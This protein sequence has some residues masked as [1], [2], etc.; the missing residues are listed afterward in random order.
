LENRLSGSI[1][2]YIKNADDLIGA[3]TFPP[4]T[5]IY[6]GSSAQNTSLVNYADLRTT[7]MDLQLN[8]VNFKGPLEWN[9]AFLFNYVKNTVTGYSESENNGIFNYL[10]DPYTP[11][12]GESRDILLAL[13][14][15]KLDPS[16]GS[17]PM[18][19][20]GERVY[21]A[22]TYLNS[23]TKDDLITVGTKVP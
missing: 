5:G 2:Y 15:Y 16:D 3:R 4:N 11:I 23:L 19:L 14:K 18:Y 22:S 17:V 9:T 6:E 21:N 1:E 10:R 8:S 12:E 20:N 13:P 7:G